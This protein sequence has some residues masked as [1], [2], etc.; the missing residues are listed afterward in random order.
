MYILTVCGMGLGTSLMLLMEIQD[1][2]KKHGFSIDGEATDL[3]GVKGRKCDAIV[4]SSQ[5]AQQISDVHTTII[6]IINMIDKNE[7]ESKVLPVI[8]KYYEKIGE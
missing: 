1:I 8:Q 4:A 6:P 2:A 5:I 7:V 3:S